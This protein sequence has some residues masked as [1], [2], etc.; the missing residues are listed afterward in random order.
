MPRTILD[1]GSEEDIEGRLGRFLE[2]KERARSCCLTSRLSACYRK[3]CY[4]RRF[5]SCD[6]PRPR[7]HISSKR[8]NVERRAK[9][10][11]F[12]T[13]RHSTVGSEHY[14]SYLRRDRPQGPCSGVHVSAKAK[15]SKKIHLDSCEFVTRKYADQHSEA[16]T[17]RFSRGEMSR[18]NWFYET[19]EAS[20]FGE[21]SAVYSP[22]GVSA[23]S[24]RGPK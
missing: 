13:K 1:D 9:R 6:T 2:R 11:V 8:A 23:C 14:S 15:S 21:E 3:R 24:H 20:W 18:T 22:S 7:R 10:L 16:A 12:E 5:H 19:G 4:Y 17:A